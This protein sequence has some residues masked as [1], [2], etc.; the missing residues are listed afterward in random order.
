V[1]RVPPGLSVPRGITRGRNQ[2]IYTTCL[3]CRGSLGSNEVLERFPVGRRV[4]YDPARGRLWVVCPGC[5]QWCLTPFDERWEVIEDAER[6]YRGTR[7]RAATDQIG[8]ARMKDGSELVRIGEP[9]RPEFAA[10]RYGARFGARWRRRAAVVVGAGAVVGAYIVAGPVM[11]LVAGGVGTIPWN[12]AQGA[13]GYLNRRRVTARVDTDRGPVAMTDEHL[14]HARLVADHARQP[15]WQL[16]V[17]HLREDVRVGRFT[18]RTT[19]KDDAM[20]SLRGEEAVRAARSMMPRINRWGGRH[21]AVQQAVEF[22][23]SSGSPDQGFVAVTRLSGD[24]PADLS[25]LPLAQ[26]LALEMAAHDEIE[27]RALE[28]E[29]AALEAAWQEAEEVAAI[30]DELT[31]PER[32]VAQFERLKG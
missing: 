27:R 13:M 5:R 14:S 26:R 12:L 19:T 11:G 15:G 9:M 18:S 31:L 1:G 20:I 10:W 6:I 4:A 2:H 17:P 32:V 29:L 3:F 28:G 25:K 16:W 21:A 30:S 24:A 22:L 23:E 7:L 8:L